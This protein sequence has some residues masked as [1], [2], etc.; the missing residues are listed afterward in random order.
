VIDQNGHRFCGKR[1]NSRYCEF[2][3]ALYR[4]VFLPIEPDSIA[5]KTY[6]VPMETLINVIPAQAEIYNSLIFMDS[7]LRESDKNRINRSFPR[8]PANSSLEEK[9]LYPLS[10]NRPWH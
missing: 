3:I 1:L 4:L 8:S 5:K 6:N 7:R 9:W 2:Q 10:A